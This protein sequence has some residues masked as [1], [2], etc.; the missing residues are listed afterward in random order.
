MTKTG[1][2]HDMYLYVKSTIRGEN[3]RLR[4]ASLM[5]F[6]NLT[7]STSND[8]THLQSLFSNSKWQKAVWLFSHLIMCI[9]NSI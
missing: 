7:A 9:I 3:K 1:P 6:V 8:Q 2:N 4:P 5:Q